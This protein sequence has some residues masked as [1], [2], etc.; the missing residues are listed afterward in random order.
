MF[1][2]TR[3]EEVLTELTSELTTFFQHELSHLFNRLDF[4]L[5]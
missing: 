3:E 4:I 2:T 5:L 1:L